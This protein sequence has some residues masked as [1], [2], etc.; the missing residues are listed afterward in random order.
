MKPG[1]V[2]DCGGVPGSGR[3]GFRP[4]ASLVLLR[5]VGPVTQIILIWVTLFRHPWRNNPSRFGSLGS[6]P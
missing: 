5:L 6:S 3:P 4:S 2:G 1:F